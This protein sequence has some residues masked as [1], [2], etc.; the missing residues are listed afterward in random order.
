MTMELPTAEL[1]SKQRTLPVCPLLSE[2]IWR[3]GIRW[4][5]SHSL[6]P[7]WET[8]RHSLALETTLLWK[9]GEDHWM[10]LHQVTQCSILKM[11]PSSPHPAHILSSSHHFSFLSFFPL[12]LLPLLSLPPF[13]PHTHHRY[14][15]LLISYN[16]H[17]TPTLQWGSHQSLCL[18]GHCLHGNKCTPVHLHS[19]T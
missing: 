15:P 19:F 6:P 8:K 14:L 10:L 7:S 9:E 17:F 4:T 13:S 5:I 3:E 16:R 12:Y 11:Q 18:C 1:S 2:W